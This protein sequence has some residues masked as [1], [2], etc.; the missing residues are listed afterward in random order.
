MWVMPRLTSKMTP[1]PLLDDYHGNELGSL[2]IEQRAGRGLLY[3][4]HMTDVPIVVTGKIK[5]EAVP[6]YDLSSRLL[7]TRRPGEADYGN[8]KDIERGGYLEGDNV[9]G[10]DS[11]KEE[12]GSDSDV[13]LGAKYKLLGNSYLRRKCGHFLPEYHKVMRHYYN[14]KSHEISVKVFDRALRLLE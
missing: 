8:V 12:Y 13:E 6:S 4:G 7:S 1:Y 10:R 9:I 11:F 5:R 14:C 3:V 2:Y